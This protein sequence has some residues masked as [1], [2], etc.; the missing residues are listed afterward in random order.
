VLVRGESAGKTTLSLLSADLK[1]LST[2]A[3][4]ASVRSLVLYDYAR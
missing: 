3:E 1:V 2:M 4:P